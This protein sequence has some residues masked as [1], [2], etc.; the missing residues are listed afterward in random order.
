MTM[1][2]RSL[3]ALLSLTASAL[4]GCGSGSGSSSSSA[5]APGTTVAG[6]RPSSPAAVTILSPR[7]GAVIS[8]GMVH[9]EVTVSGA[10]VVQTTSQSISPTQGH[11]HLFLDGDLTYM[12][13]T[14][15]QD[16][17]LTHPGNYVLLAEF[18]ASDH[19]PFNPR[20][21]SA[22]VLFTVPPP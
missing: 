20:V 9:I 22:K 7:D 21:M 18:V 17:P 6:Q 19:I 10:Q 1:R 15:K 3:L 8:G 4:A 5:S 14:L 13:Y 12:S 16:L 11:V 2:R